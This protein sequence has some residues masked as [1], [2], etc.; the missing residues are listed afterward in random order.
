MQW[1]Q[2]PLGEAGSD[3]LD[4][5]EESIQAAIEQMFWQRAKRDSLSFGVGRVV[6]ESSVIRDMRLN[7]QKRECDGLIVFHAG[8]ALETT[9]QLIYAKINNRILGR[10]YPDAPEDQLNQDR[11]THSLTALYNK[12]LKS[13][14]GELHQQLEQEFESIFQTVH[15]EGLN[16]FIVDDEIVYSFYRE[17]DAPFW[18]TRMGGLRHGVEKTMDHSNTD[19][20]LNLP[21]DPSDFAKMPHRNFREFLVKAD[22]V[23]YDKRNMR[24]AHYS[25]RDHEPGRAYV[26][27]GPRFFARLVRGLVKMSE[28]QWMWDKQFARRWH[29]RNQQ[30]IRDLVSSCLDQN[31]TGTSDLPTSKS[32]DEMMRSSFS[33]RSKR[34]SD[35]DSLHNRLRFKRPT[36]GNEDES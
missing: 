19:Q 18:E 14:E 3:Q 6:K 4:A 13:V 12:I 35:Y 5:M 29:E 27:V 28:E 31:F 30:N 9:L 24:W 17:G 20:L 10:N 32:V 22:S 2:T 21:E 11:R 36:Q 34:R 8:K 16:D 26:V 33:R 23:Y 15:H 1:F 25:A 7:A